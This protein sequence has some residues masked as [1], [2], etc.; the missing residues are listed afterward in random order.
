M[1]AIIP[2]PAATPTSA[3]RL[4]PHACPIP[5]SA[6]YSLIT[7]IFGLASAPYVALKAV[8]S[9]YDRST[10]ETKLSMSIRIF[11]YQLIICG[12]LGVSF[13]I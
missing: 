2:M 1:A 4:C 8:S 9:L 3:I 11:E 6:S 13:H 5:G 7:Q 10:C 12:I